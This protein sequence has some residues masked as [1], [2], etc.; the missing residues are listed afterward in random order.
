MPTGHSLLYV[1]F[2]ACCLLLAVRLAREVLAPI[3]VLLRAAAALT[4][5]VLAISVALIMMITAVLTGAGR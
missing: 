5:F 3:G 4:A 2:A 1:A